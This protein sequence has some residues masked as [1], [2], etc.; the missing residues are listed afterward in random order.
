MDPALVAF[1]LAQAAGRFGS[2][3]FPLKTLAA[4]TGG[5]SG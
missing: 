1:D 2:D 4:A 3:R 5:D